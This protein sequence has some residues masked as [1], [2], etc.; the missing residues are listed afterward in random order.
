MSQDSVEH[1]FVLF[2]IPL[3]S[4]YEQTVRA[5]DQPS[6]LVHK[7]RTKSEVLYSYGNTYAPAMCFE[8]KLETYHCSMT[9]GASIGSPNIIYPLGLKWEVPE[10]SARQY[11]VGVACIPVV[12]HSVER[13][14]ELRSRHL[15]T[16]PGPFAVCHYSCVATKYLQFKLFQRLVHLFHSELMLRTRIG[17]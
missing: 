6:H 9:H 11:I 14:P 8:C 7:L 3:T 12:R 17:C 15:R 2:A 16:G 1:P 5:I 13:V 10:S 4:I